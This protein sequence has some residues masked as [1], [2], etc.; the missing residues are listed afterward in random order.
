MGKL[1]GSTPRAFQS[2]TDVAP[3]LPFTLAPTAEATLDIPAAVTAQDILA[4]ATVP[5]IPAVAMAQGT[6][7]DTVQV[8]A[9]GMARVT[10]RTI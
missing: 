5:V 8:T 9:P 4:V 10:A 6:V 1:G 3:Y 2:I 7:P